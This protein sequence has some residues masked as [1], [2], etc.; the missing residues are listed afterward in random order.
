MKAMVLEE[1]NQP[2]KLRELDIPKPAADEV[3]IKVRACSI[4]G[5][6]LKI[7][8]GKIDT[9]P[10][11][12]IP[13]HESTGDV[14]EIGAE[15]KDLKVG[16]RVTVDL[17]VTCGQCKNCLAG[18]NTICMESI[19]RYGFEVNGGFA[20][21]MVVK[22]E[23]AVKVPDTMTYPEAALIPDAIATS[24]RAFADRYHL[25]EGEIVLV[26]GIGGLGIHG[27]QVAKAYGAT[28][29]AADVDNKK[30]QRAKELGADYT[31]NTAEEDLVA[32]C[33]SLTNGYGVDVVGEYVGIPKVS[34]LGLKCLRMGGT[35][36]FLGYAPGT[37]FEVPSMDIAMG[38]RTITGSRAMDRKSML[39]AIRLVSEGKV[40]PQVD[41]YFALEDANAALERLKGEGYLGRGLLAIDL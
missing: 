32:F 36:I 27:V 26:L 7:I 38:E 30:L 1:F 2:L 10:L 41:S 14:I 37:V 6:D 17:Y 20:E 39:E 9:V 13:G 22:E 4:C 40:K 33:K 11:P 24:V 16:D 25:Q 29:I 5:T 8:S 19:K 18:R 15:V 35:M 3:L 28:V 12:L 23:K 31:C 34:E 21:Y